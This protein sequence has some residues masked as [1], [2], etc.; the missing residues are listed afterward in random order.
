[1]CIKGLYKA[2]DGSGG[3]LIGMVRMAKYE[4]VAPVLPELSYKTNT[5]VEIVDTNYPLTSNSMSV[6]I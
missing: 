4:P 2:I 5:G 3:P 6:S 1:M